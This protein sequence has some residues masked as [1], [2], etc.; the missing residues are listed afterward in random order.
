MTDILTE[1]TVLRPKAVLDIYS[2][3]GKPTERKNRNA[4][5]ILY[6]YEGETHYTSGGRT[7][8]SNAGSAMLL[9]QG[10]SYTWQ[11]ME[12]GH[13][14]TIEFETDI[15]SEQIRS[16]PLGTEGERL[17]R[18]MREAEHKYTLRA[19]GYRLEL[20][21]LIYEALLLLAGTGRKEYA[22]A[23][24]RK[25]LTPAL[26]YISENYAAMPKND[27][28]ASL[29]GISTVYFRKLF[30]RVVGC[31]PIAYIHRL[32]IAKAKRMLE[33]DYEHLSAIALSLGYPDIYTFS[34]AFK[35]QAGL[36]PTHYLKQ[37][38]K[39]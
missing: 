34:K 37:K 25:K 22:D 11:C 32:R 28:L 8:V 31:S 33:S 2:D 38:T 19:P 12:G 20:M 1:L 39:R 18:I 14:C 35:K 29:C 4:F 23:A 17:L 24:H 6:K 15:A 3:P 5:A 7:F 26:D 9:P 30:P 10:S 13:Y 21:H 36:S 16:I 27:F